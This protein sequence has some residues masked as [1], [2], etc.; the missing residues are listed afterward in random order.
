MKK[1]C[2]CAVSGA[3]FVVSVGC[4]GGDDASPALPSSDASSGGSSGSGAANGA[5]TGGSFG[6]GRGGSAGASNGAGGSSLIAGA[7]GTAPLGSGGTAPQIKPPI[8][9][10]SAG[11]DSSSAGASS[12]SDPDPPSAEDQPATNPFVMTAHDPLST[13]AADVDTASYDVFRRDVNLGALPPPAGVRLEEYVNYFSYAY[14]APALDAPH[15]FAL[16]LAAAPSLFARDTL[17][18]RV[19]IQGA[20]PSES[21]KRPANVVFLVDT[22]GSMASP[23]KLPLVQLTLIE[24]LNVLAPADVV[25]IVTYSDTADV[26]LA[27]TPV[28]QKEAITSVIESLA[29]AG[30]TA[31]APGIDMAYAQAESAFVEGGI[32]HV[33]LCT[34]GDFNVGPY[35]TEEL[36]DLIV[37]KRKTGVT[38]TALGYGADNLNDRMMEAVSNAGN[39]VYGMISNADQAVEYV[40]ERLLSTLIHIAK[41]MKI[42]VEF[43]AERVLAYRLL[44]YENRAIADD[45]F[46]DDV[47]DAGEIGAGHRVTALYEI[48]LAGD[49][50]PEVEGAPEPLDGEAYAGDKEILPAD[51]ALV[52][53]RYK[54]PNAA[55][56]DPAREVAAVLSADAPADSP[57]ALDGDFRW[58]LAVASFAEILKRSP[59]ADPSR[60][61]AI[62]EIVHSAEYA[63]D[64]DRSEFKS[65]FD[66]ASARLEP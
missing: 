12:E 3:V 53:I 30:S 66:A 22:S 11:E 10:G 23:D 13:F 37:D 17:M 25:S 26:R 6:A 46:R 7:A 1:A 15:P 27:P 51:L 64:A 36:V 14:P 54:A 32:N 65:L 40:N 35:T 50:L 47:V 34:D 52:K 16:E 9:E 61:D 63:S 45:D 28:S 60:L 57:A 29:A 62:R 44:G 20:T 39:G 18:L 21:E 5:T 49:E 19:G 56:S 2:L 31:G 48:V 4:G 58:A 24:T 41:D 38:L 8:F 55:E 43:N 33:V 42:Q 59:Y